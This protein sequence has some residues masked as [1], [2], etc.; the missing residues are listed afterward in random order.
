VKS[1]RTQ[2][3][4]DAF[5]KLPKSIQTKARRAFRHFRSNP[6]H[7]GLQFKLIDKEN[8]VYS[9]R[10]DQNYRALAVRE[11]DAWVWFWIGTHTEYDKFIAHL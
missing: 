2:D 5:N 1:R 7:P 6:Q 9:A 11:D 4:K 3:F 8:E 10:I